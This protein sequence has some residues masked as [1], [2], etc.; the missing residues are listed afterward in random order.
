RVVWT[1]GR[2]ACFSVSRKQVR[3]GGAR[4][5]RVVFGGCVV[6]GLRPRGIT[7]CP[8]ILALVGRGGVGDDMVE[9]SQ[10]RPGCP[11]AVVV[12][13]RPASGSPVAGRSVG[14]NRCLGLDGDRRRGSILG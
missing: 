14:R 3:V 7:V 2:A 5:R 4:C 13:G 6:A 9:R 1:R 12:P 8:P 10:S 11:P